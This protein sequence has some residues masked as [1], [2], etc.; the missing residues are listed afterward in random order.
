MSRALLRNPVLWTAIVLLAMTGIAVLAGIPLGR[1][2]QIAIYVLYGAG[3]NLLIA[4]TGLVPFGASV[5]F[6]TGTYAAA[7]FML[8][9]S[10]NEFAGLGF[11]ILWSVAAGALLGV[12]VLRRRGLYF[13]LLTL[14]AS[15]IAYE[16]AFRWTALTGGENGLQNVPRTTFAT[17][18]QFHLFTLAVLILSLWVIWRFVHAPFGRALQAIRDNEPRMASLG[19]DTQRLKLGAFTV[20]GTFVGLA[21]GLL[22]LLL[23]G[24]YANNLSWQHAG[25]ALLMVVLGGVHHALGALWGAAVFILLED[26]LSAWLENWW[27]VFAPLIIVF[28][29]AAPEGLH[30]LARRLTGR[31]GWSLVRPGIPPR[32]ASITPFAPAAGQEDAA[33]PMLTVRGLHKS[34]GSLAVARDLHLDVMPRRLHSI[35]GPN[36]AGKTTLFNMLAG[37]VTPDAGEIRFLGTDITAMATHRR[38]RLGL[39]R[40]FQIVSVFA[41]L[42]AFENVRIA[43]QAR[44]PHRFGLWRDAH[45]LAAV[46]DRSWSLLA[47]VGLE[48]RAA[49]LCSSLSHGERRLLEIAITLATEARLLLL[50]EPLAGLAEPDRI[51][52]ARLLRRLADSHAVLLIEHDLDR[53]VSLSDRI[54]VLHQG[55]LIADGA[56]AE[57]VRDPAVV[58][59]YLGGAAAEH[60]APPIGPTVA[61][62]ARKPLLVLE[63]VTAGYGGSRI[64]DRVDLVVHEGEALALLGRNGVGKTTLLRAI[65]GTVPITEGRILFDGI[66][67]SGR[68]SF[69]INRRGIAIVPE[70]RRLFPNLTVR[71]NLR[72]AER[73]GG[74]SIEEAFELFPRL[75][76]RAGIRAESL[77]G[78]ERQMCAIARALMAPARLVLMDEPFEG[79]AP[80]VVAE[81]TLAVARLRGRVAI[82]LVEHHAEKLLPLV[83]RAH[84]LVNGRTAFD[85]DAAVLAADPALQARL[86]GVVEAEAMLH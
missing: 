66:P 69:A 79:L 17:P 64:L 30:G 35:I 63:G 44:S 81:L 75:R 61:A 33:T 38:I 25:D 16:V 77:S 58:A 45:A 73:P 53:V 59:A 57:V 27:L 84:V 31:Q 68:K 43:A 22:A 74:S 49:E 37:G 52:V 34:F 50:D 40:S 80:S 18:L 10:G 32:P 11:T 1:V 76:H 71:D 78:G 12:V 54:T 20:A 62:T 14:A 60:A 39:G 85:G 13:S 55:A 24:A 65:T 3:V 2:T 72:I 26:K 15:Q 47:A 70:G 8:H 48:G 9:V 51:V 6:G 86:L 23:Q 42:S 4:Y 7:L 5:F 36:G 29:L 56:P 41:N 82:V 21:G 83:D 19:Y 46:N 28:A 67:I